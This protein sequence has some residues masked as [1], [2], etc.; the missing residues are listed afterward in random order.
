M[1]CAGMMPSRPC[2]HERRERH[3]I[4]RRDRDRTVRSSTG[5]SDVRVG[6]DESV[7]RKVLAHRRHPAGRAGRRMK[8]SREMRDGIGI[9]MQ[10]AI[11]DDRALAVVEIEDRREAEI[12]A[13]G[14]KLGGDRPAQA[15]GF[16]RRAG[17]IAVPPLAQRA[18]RRYRREAVAKALHPS[19]FVIDGDQ[20][21]RL[22]QRA[23]RGG[24]PASWR[25]R[26]EIAR[27]QDDAAR[28]ADAR[29]ARGRPPTAPD[30]RRRAS[31]GPRGKHCATSRL[32]RG[33][34]ANQRLHLPH[35]LAHA[36]ENRRARRS[37]DR[38]AAR[39]RRATRRPAAR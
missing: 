38:C 15:R 35:G 33:R 19:A 12:D 20:Q 14:A 28:R 11:A 17:D 3:E 30:P 24:Q 22:A 23:D 5:S 18:H 16:A 34:L 6:G 9:A 7:S 4:V 31:T 32:R 8:R 26:L 29:G 1:T 13:R 2:L 27:E 25:G 39:A 21:R 36:D 10:R 37:H